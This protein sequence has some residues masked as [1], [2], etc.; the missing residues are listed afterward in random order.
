MSVYDNPK[1]SFPFPWWVYVLIILGVIA[2][3]FISGELKLNLLN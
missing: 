3:G 1:H 2:Y